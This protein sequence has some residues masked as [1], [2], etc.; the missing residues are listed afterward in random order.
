MMDDLLVLINVE[1]KAA[2]MVALMALWRDLK[3]DLPKV[4]KKVM[5]REIK[6]ASEKGERT[7][8]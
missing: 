4:V 1:S 3:M 6:L 8:G 5:K 2:A 7:V